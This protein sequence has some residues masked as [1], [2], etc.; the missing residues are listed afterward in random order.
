MVTVVKGKGRAIRKTDFTVL[1]KA[2]LNTKTE[3]YF[4][5]RMNFSWLRIIKLQHDVAFI[6]LRQVGELDR[7][8]AGQADSRTDGRTKG[9]P[10]LYTHGP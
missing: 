3:G 1:E 9:P 4:K 2:T 8:T 5:V 7:R 6:V 10:I